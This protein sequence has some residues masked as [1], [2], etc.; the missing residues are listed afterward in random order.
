M[1]GKNIPWEPVPECIGLQARRYADRSTY[2]YRQRIGGK[3]H[4][5]AIGGV[6]EGTAIALA[7]MLR[8]IAPA[9]WQEVEDDLWFQVVEEKVDWLIFEMR[10]E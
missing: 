7:G 9:Q 6:V 1:P 4:V 2:R 5:H 3:L 8:C 10:N